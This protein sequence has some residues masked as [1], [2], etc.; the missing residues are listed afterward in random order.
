M[1]FRCDLCNVAQPQGTKQH[2]VEGE[3]RAKQYRNMVL[4]DDGVSK[5]ELV[6]Q[7]YETVSELKCCATCAGVP[8]P[9]PVAPPD[10]KT[11]M[12]QADLRHAHARG[13]KKDPTECKLCIAGIRWFAALPPMILNEVL[14]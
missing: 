11:I 3:T 7:G 10:L 4:A 13:C 9:A 1:G 2:I 8:L 14:S 5:V 12:T 6:S